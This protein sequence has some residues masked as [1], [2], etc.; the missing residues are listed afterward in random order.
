MGNRRHARKL[1]DKVQERTFARQKFV[2]RSVHFGNQIAFLDYIAVFLVERHLG[3]RLEFL[4]HKFDNREAGEYAIFLGNQAGM[5]FLVGR[6]GPFARDIA[7]ANILGKRQANHGQSIFGRE[8]WCGIVT[9]H[10]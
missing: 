8:N 1:L 5:L 2:R 3:V 10:H 7:R 6:N 9:V 4:E